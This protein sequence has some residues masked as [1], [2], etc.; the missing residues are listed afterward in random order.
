VL[1]QALVRW[2]PAGLADR[3]LDEREALGF[4]P[5]TTIVALDGPAPDVEEVAA[6]S[7]GELMG[8][9][10]RSG[11]QPGGATGEGKEEATPEV[12]ALVRVAHGDAPGLLGALAR[13][14]QHRAAHRL[15]MVR[16]TVNPPELF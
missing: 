2:D 6:G 11:P 3:L 12:R 7:G 10:P 14:Q 4:F 15:P 5:A 16:I 8:I 13:I 9:V 1:S